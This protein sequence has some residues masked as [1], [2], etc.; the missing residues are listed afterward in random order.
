LDAG[1]ATLELGLFHVALE[2][3]EPTT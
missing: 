1:V 2:R 3:Q